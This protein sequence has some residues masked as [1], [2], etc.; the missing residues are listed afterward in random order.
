MPKEVIDNKNGKKNIYLLGS[1]SFFNDI[2]SEMI[3]PLLPFYITALGGTG[4]AIG[5][6]SGLREGLSSVLKFFGGWFSDR[7]GKRKH[8]IFSGYL[9]SVIFRLMLALANVWQQVIAFVSLERIGKIRDAP[10]DAIIASSTTKRGKGFGIHQMMDTLG[11][12]VGT[13]LVIIILWKLNLSL[14]TII[15]I[16]AAISASSLIPLFFVKEKKTKPIRATIFGSLKNLPKELYYLIFVASVAAL[17]NFGLYLF[18]ILMAKELTGSIITSLVIYALFSIVYASSTIPFGSL[19]D[20]IG[21]K[22]VL[23]I[24]YTLFFVLMLALISSPSLIFL[25]IIFMLYGVVMAI[26]EPTQRAFVSDLA[27]EAK[28]TAL[29]AY[30][31]IRGITTIIGGLIA[32]LIWDI[33][34]GAM[35]SYLAVISF[36]SLVLLISLKEKR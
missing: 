3:T 13:I 25:S 16:A 33:S 30:H 17:A 23:L 8:I 9:M 4:A 24:G 18:L 19:S 21:R 14:R 12:V 29:G 35:F 22:K 34:P 6:I 1:S 31:S 36:I 2:G 26:T 15:I 27:G 20:K 5:L 10:R 7:I 32:G 28:G 11:G